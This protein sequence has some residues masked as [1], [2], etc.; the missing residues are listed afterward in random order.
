MNKQ[1]LVDALA[2]ETGL[3]KTDAA[4]AIDGLVA[5][6]GDTLAGG[7]SVQLV[8]FGTFAVG[9]RAA[10][11]GRNPKTGEEIKIPASKVPKFTAGAKLK[12]A[13]SGK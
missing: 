4:K 11:V 13:V 5:V 6:I 12:A 7:D 1:E 9:S 3:T 10:R 2:A 8:G